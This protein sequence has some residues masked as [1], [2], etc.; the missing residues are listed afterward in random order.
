M[1]LFHAKMAPPI[2]F[3]EIFQKFSELVDII[4]IV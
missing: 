1:Q 3:F 4:A 2:I